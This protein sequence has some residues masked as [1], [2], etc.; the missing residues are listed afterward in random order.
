[1]IGPVTDFEARFGVLTTPSPST[2][3]V[4]SPGASESVVTQPLHGTPAGPAEPSLPTVH[5]AN[6]A[7]IAARRV[8]LN[9][10]FTDLPPTRF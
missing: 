3:L 10:R 5:A 8:V 1:M 6:E 4:M 7:A 2:A 9:I